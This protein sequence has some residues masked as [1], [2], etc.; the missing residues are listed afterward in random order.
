M[1]QPQPANLGTWAESW[2]TSTQEPLTTPSTWLWSSICFWKLKKKSYAASENTCVAVV[3]LFK[4]LENL[5]LFQLM[6][7]KE[8][9][10]KNGSK[11]PA[12]VISDHILS[13]KRLKSE[14]QT[15][16]TSTS[17]AMINHS[18][19]MDSIKNQEH[20][21]IL[22]FTFGRQQHLRHLQANILSYFFF[23]RS[24]KCFL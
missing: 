12:S 4:W 18:D 2:A 7:Y 14:Y 20:P 9:W 15:Y 1:P 22:T 24:E 5:I 21:Q 17:R 8:N 19:E 6:W 16:K 11:F 10:T 13:C 3:Q 23:L